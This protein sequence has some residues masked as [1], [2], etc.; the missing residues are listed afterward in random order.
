MNLNK[1][2]ML[3]MMLAGC[4]TM[5]TGF[6]SY[7]ADGSAQAV[8]VGNIHHEGI[9]VAPLKEAWESIPEAAKLA[10]VTQEWYG[11][12]LA[13]TDGEADVLA[14]AQDGSQVTGKIYKDT[15]IHIV[16]QGESFTKIAAGQVNGYVRNELLITGNNAVERAKTVCPDGAKDNAK[17]MEQIAAEAEAERIAAEAAAQAEA[18]RL[19]A[20]QASAY[21][22]ELLAALIFCEAGNQP[23]EGQVAVGAVVM[24]RVR[25]GIFPGTIE[26]VIY[27]S[28]QFG[29][30]ITGKLDRILSSGG[31]TDSSMQAAADALA[32]SNP[33]GEAL[34]FGNGNYGQ[35]IGDHYF[36]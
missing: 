31:Y 10:A 16:E 14:E 17:T 29:P 12:A 33:I 6:L 23:Y 5:T 1:K 19:A 9:T 24:N 13:D 4:M 18:E 20:E 15:M 21:E 27:Q 7:A 2:R 3:A 22:Q 32:G 30:A 35:L 36:H 26:E 28:G 34:Y 11:K 8:P 25:S